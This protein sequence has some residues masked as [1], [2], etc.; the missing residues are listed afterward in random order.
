[1]CTLLNLTP[2]IVLAIVFIWKDFAFFTVSWCH[3]YIAA[4]LLSKILFIYFNHP[5][6]QSVIVMCKWDTNDTEPTCLSTWNEEISI[7]WSYWF[8]FLLTTCSC[9]QLGSKTGS[10]KGLWC[11]KSRWKSE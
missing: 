1:V 11:C 8:S 4:I 2:C 9:M 7:V 10:G 3:L 6:F 5:N